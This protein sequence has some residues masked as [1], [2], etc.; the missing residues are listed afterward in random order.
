MERARS[1]K[2]ANAIPRLRRSAAIV[3]LLAAACGSSN[4]A[5]QENSSTISCSDSIGASATPSSEL[6]VFDSAVA[7]ASARSPRALQTSRTNRSAVSERLFAKSG[8]E[9]RDDASVIISSDNGDVLLGWGN[10]ALPSRTINVQGCK[11]RG[12]TA[13]SG[14]FWVE[15]PRCAAVKI[16]QGKREFVVDVGIGA[17]CPGQSDPLPPTDR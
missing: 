1:E 11:G 15:S 12:W 4:G 16:S 3:V 14:G 7:I 5:G 2:L 10:P 6:E 9:I 17:P 13:F 8:L